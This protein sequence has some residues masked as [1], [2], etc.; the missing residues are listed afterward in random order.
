[1]LLDCLG[2]ACPMPIIK[3]KN[4]LKEIG[5]DGVVSVLTDNI[6][7][8]ENIE[9]MARA[10]GCPCVIEKSG[11]NYVISITKGTGEMAPKTSKE[12]IND[13]VVVISSLCMGNGN[14][15]LGAALLKTFIYTLTEL[16]VLPK[17]LIFYNEGVILACESSSIGDINTLRE[18]GVDVLSCGACLEYYGLTNSLKTGRV[19]NMYEIAGMMI[20]ASGII[21]P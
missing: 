13:A 17:A 3:A 11:E 5:E 19:S 16:D 8:V 12:N 7:S 20:N 2:E 1:M 18:M 15:E 21:K 4:A 9:K 6:E 14:D 10:A